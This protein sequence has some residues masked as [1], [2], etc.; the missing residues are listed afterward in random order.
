M[1]T[2]A[3]DSPL[4]ERVAQ[5]HGPGHEPADDGSVVELGA[6]AVLDPETLA[7]GLAGHDSQPG[8]ALLQGYVYKL[9]KSYQSRVRRKGLSSMLVN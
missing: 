2:G 6:L 8:G 1:P 4:V 3:P 7:E 9:Q 5:H